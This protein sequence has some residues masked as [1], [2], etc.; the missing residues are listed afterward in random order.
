MSVRTRL[1]FSETTWNRPTETPRKL[2]EDSGQNIK[3][4]V[5]ALKPANER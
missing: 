1:N 4:A 5:K 2:A 3:R